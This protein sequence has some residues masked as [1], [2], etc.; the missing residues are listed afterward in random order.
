M[1]AGYL[2]AARAQQ[3]RLLDEMQAVTGRHRK[4]LLRLLHAAD[5]RRT[6][7]APSSVAPPMEHGSTMPFG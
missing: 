5:L 3:S 7:S 6:V 2:L 4:R 1:R